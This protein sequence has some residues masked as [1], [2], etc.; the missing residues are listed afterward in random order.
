MTTVEIVGKEIETRD[1]QKRGLLGAMLSDNRP[2]QSTALV[3]V[4]V[5]VVR[6][7]THQGKTI[8]R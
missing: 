8:M 1:E 4:S 6:T 3:V 2:R 5:D 7:S